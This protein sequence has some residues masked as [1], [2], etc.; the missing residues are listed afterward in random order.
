MPGAEVLAELAGVEVTLG[1]TKVL[2]GIDL[3]VRR[4]QAVSVIGPSGSGKSTLLRCIAGLQPVESGTVTVCG[5][6]VHAL[7]KH[8]AKRPLWRRVGVVFQQFNLFPHLT[9]LQNLTIAPTRALG[10][11]AGEV[12]REARALLDRVGLADKADAYPSELSGGQ[13]QR[14]AIARSLAMK[15]ELIL[16]DEVTSALDPET[17]GEVLAIIRDL[18]RGGMTCL[19]VTHELRFAE[20]ISDEIHF[21]EGGVVVEHGPPA[22]LFHAPRHDRTRAFVNRARP[23]AP[24]IPSDRI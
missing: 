14:V 3:A 18:V 9:A 12:E 15:P 16:F 24:A 20:E 13:Q 7:R 6:P 19:L 22:A 10:R 1:G 8:E 17:V 5:L 23:G 2:R 21:T 11:D 4:G